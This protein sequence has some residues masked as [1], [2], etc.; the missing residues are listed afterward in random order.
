VD[1]QSSKFTVK[2]TLKSA[3]DFDRSLADGFGASHHHV[4]PLLPLVLDHG[5]GVKRVCSDIVHSHVHNITVGAHTPHDQS[6]QQLHHALFACARAHGGHFG[7]ITGA[8]SYCFVWGW[9]LSWKRRLY[10]VSRG[11]TVSAGSVCVTNLTHACGCGLVR[12]A[13]HVS[14]AASFE[15]AWTQRPTL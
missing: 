5:A 1:A 11:S 13:A 9:C 6:W 7:R 2:F 12:T 15:P 3:V 10:D 4:T 8:P 14:V